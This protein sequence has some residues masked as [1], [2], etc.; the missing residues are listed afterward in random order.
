[1]QELKNT[2]IIKPP[3][4]HSSK[5]FSVDST[6][7]KLAKLLFDTIRKRKPDFKEPNLQVWAVHIDLMIRRDGRKPDRIA[8]VI[9]WCQADSGDGGKWKGWQDNV[10]CTETLR[11]KFDQLELRMNKKGVRQ[12]GSDSGNSTENPE[13]TYR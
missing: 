6:E 10:L 2:T 11:K 9:Q 13:P 1:M 8:E 12:Y 5:I 3:K 4:E 7:F